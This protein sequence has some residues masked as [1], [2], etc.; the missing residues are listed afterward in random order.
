[1]RAA[2][3]LA[4]VLNGCGYTMSS[5]L[6]AEPARTLRLDTIENRL[7]PYR[8]GYE[9]ELTRRLKDE[10]AVDNRLVLT[11]G[12]ADVVLQVALTRFTETTLTEDQD[13]GLP[14][15]F[16][17]QAS[18]LVVA[19]SPDLPGGENRRTVSVSE[20]YA[21]EQGDTRIRGVE[22]LWRNLARQILDA[23]ADREWA[24]PPKAPPSGE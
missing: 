15:E 9:Y 12:H 17:L 11:E 3:L 14:V 24:A 22:R 16:T 19:R 5:R 18:A 10:I 6:D 8:P 7:F 20:L 1:M 21:N 13:S 23:A 2:L 4:L